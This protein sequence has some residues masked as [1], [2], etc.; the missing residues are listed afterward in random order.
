AVIG[1]VC[2]LLSNNNHPIA[3]GQLARHYATLTPLTILTSAGTRPV[4]KPNERAG[5]L[6]ISQSTK[7]ENCFTAV[8]ILSP[9]GDTR[10]AARNLFAAL[11]RLDALGLDRIY[12][13]PC[14]DVG[15]GMAIMDRLRRCAA[16]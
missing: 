4:L 13:E 14:H 10:E 1:P 5:L 8:E 3:P 16:R 7:S 6:L 15:L 12:A 9:T 11:R 2:S